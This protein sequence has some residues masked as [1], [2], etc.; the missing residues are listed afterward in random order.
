MVGGVEDCPRG[1]VILLQLNNRGVGEV[2]L[3]VQ[4]NL[5]VRAPERIN[6][7]VNDNSSGDIIAKIGNRQIVGLAD[8]MFV[9]DG[10][11][12]AVNNDGR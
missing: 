3:K 1:T 11:D 2:A 6:G 7:I 10:C 4:D 8:I 5:D 12:L 9:G